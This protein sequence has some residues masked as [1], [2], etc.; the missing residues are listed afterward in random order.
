MCRKRGHSINTAVWRQIRVFTLF[1][2]SGRGRRTTH[3]AKPYSKLYPARSNAT[4]RSGQRWKCQHGNRINLYQP[5]NICRPTVSHTNAVLTRYYATRLTEK[6]IKCPCLPQ[7][8]YGQSHYKK[9]SSDSP[10]N[11]TLANFPYYF[12]VCMSPLLVRNVS[13]IYEC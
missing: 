6:G 11:L 9:H 13:F 3:L 2:S 1:G 5:R 8:K 4:Q 7:S 10:G 12:Y